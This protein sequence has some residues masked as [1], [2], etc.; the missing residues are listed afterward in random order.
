MRNVF[1]YIPAM[2]IAGLSAACGASDGESAGL[3]ENVREAQEALT[4]GSN[5]TTVPFNSLKGKETSASWADSTTY[6]NGT[7]VVGYILDPFGV[8]AIGW[9]VSENPAASPPGWHEHSSQ[10]PGQWPLPTNF[11]TADGTSGTKFRADPTVLGIP[12]APGNPPTAVK[13]RFVAVVGLD[14]AQPMDDVTI[15]LSTDGGFHFTSTK[16]VNDATSGN[17]VDMPVAAVDAVTGEIW[18]VWQKYSVSGSSLWLRKI[19][20]DVAGGFH[21]DPQIQITGLSVPQPPCQ[22]TLA[23][24]HD[25]A[26]QFLILAY[27]D[28]CPLGNNDSDPNQTCPKPPV[29]VNWY[30]SNSFS[31]G[32]SWNNFPAVT[33]DAAWPKCIGPG[34]SNAYKNRL[35]PELVFNTVNKHCY[36]AVNKSSPSGTLVKVY[37]SANGINWFEKSPGFPPRNTH[38][39]WAQSLG[40]VPDAR[41]GRLAVTWHDT[42][43]DSP[44]KNIKVSIYGAVSTDGGE[45]WVGPTL[46]SSTVGAV[47]SGGTIPWTATEPWGDYEGM[48]GRPPFGDFVATWADER[49]AGGK[50]VWAAVLTP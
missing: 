7:V 48:A 49:N 30:V 18:V 28:A 38:D 31:G 8:S 34:N 44:N 15:T 26:S 10:E 25:G 19:W 22:Y 43:D 13:D 35:R 37:G 1:W 4:V 45:T 16:V 20:Y 5:L 21:A 2:T 40:F 36:I 32:A 47:P 46:V 17:T 6:A 41:S 50:K 3:D 11:E 29:A 9:S 23:I 33:S 27:P 12:F 42:R 39:Q 14:T 24:G